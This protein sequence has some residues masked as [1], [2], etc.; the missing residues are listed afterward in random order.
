MS[1]AGD[2]AAG[3]DA[4]PPYRTIAE[5]LRHE[6]PKT[7]G[8]RHI[9]TIAPVATTAAAEAVVARVR[10]EMP[11]ATH[12]AFAWRLRAGDGPSGLS[13]RSSDD[14]EPSGSAGRP[15]LA[16]IDGRELTDVVVVVT[17]YFGGTKLG[18]GGL[19]RAY[20]GAAAE[21]LDLAEIVEVVPEVTLRVQPRL[22]RLGR[23]RRRPQPVRT[24]AGRA[25]V[26]RRGR[27]AGDGRDGPTG[28]TRARTARR[29]G[30]TRPHRDG[31]KAMPRP[32]QTGTR[33]SPTAADPRASTP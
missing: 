30:R 23:D 33:I 15:I 4:P 5:G 26:H 19:V 21:A 16:Q 24:P 10:D 25:G 22:R 1:P 13:F 2:P 28:R 18:V 27:A 20:G 11:D 7:K 29:D 32:A 9:A 3:N 14:G 8:S 31:L 12:H 6:P 17:R